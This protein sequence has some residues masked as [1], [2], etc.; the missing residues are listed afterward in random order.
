MTPNARILLQL[1]LTLMGAVAPYAHA[2]SES[3][4][5][6]RRVLD[7]LFSSYNSAGCC[8]FVDQLPFDEVV[9]GA[10]IKADLADRGQLVFLSPG[11]TFA[12]LYKLPHGNKEW[13]LKLRVRSIESEGLS[14][15][16]IPYVAML[17]ENY[18]IVGTTDV[19]DLRYWPANWLRHHALV[20]LV[21][22]LPKF[23]SGEGGFVLVYTRP[24]RFTTTPIGELG[25]APRTARAGEVALQLNY[26]NESEIETYKVHGLPSGT[27]EL[28]VH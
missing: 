14:H 25:E 15:V 3:D 8:E 5:D 23:A 13:S 26:A 24:R 16:M 2:N 1:L 7:N 20:Q 10:E 22:D 21:V 6:A 11:P 19:S 12:R 9:P 27:F 17:D 28:E 18:D 4:G